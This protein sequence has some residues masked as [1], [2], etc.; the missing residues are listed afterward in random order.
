MHNRHDRKCRAASNGD[1][2]GDG[3]SVYA[4][5]KTNNSSKRDAHVP[6]MFVRWRTFL[7]LVASLFISHKNEHIKRPHCRITNKN[8]RILYTKLG[9]KS[10]GCSIYYEI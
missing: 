3:T 1:S 6:I 4:P 7:R 9:V 10:C 5:I 2:R 8:K